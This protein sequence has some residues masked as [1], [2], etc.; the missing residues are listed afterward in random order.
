M[1]SVMCFVFCGFSALT[2]VAMVA[3][4]APEEIYPNKPIRLVVPYLPGGSTDILA[5]LMTAKLSADWHQTIVIENRAGAGGSIGTHVVSHAPSDGYTLL[6]AISSIV[7]S[8]AINPQSDADPLR[9]FIPITLIARS[10]YRFVI[11]PALPVSNIYEWHALAK[12]KPDSMNYGTAGIGSGVHL[13]VEYFKLMSGLEVNHVPY[14]GSPPAMNDLMGG[15]IQFMF[16]GTLSTLAYTKSGKLKA[17]AVTSL[18]RRPDSPDLPTIAETIVPHFDAGEWFGIFAPRGLSPKLLAKLQSAF[19][20]VVNTP[21]I[22]ARLQAEGMEPSAGTAQDF[23]QFIKA[24]QVK[25]TKVAKVIKI[26]PN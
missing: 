23:F 8:P 21:E 10:P 18:K 22:L 3:M 13:A 20:G 15:Q 6:L 25:W 7:T 1:K 16:G 17:L 4:A 14:K 26:S 12:A 11:N 2:M 5:R 19:R 24:E 9:V